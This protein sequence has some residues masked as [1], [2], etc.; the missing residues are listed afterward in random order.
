MTTKLCLEHR[1]TCSSIS[2]QSLSS[3]LEEANFICMLVTIV[4]N[5]AQAFLI[6]FNQILLKEPLC[7]SPVHSLILC[8]T[9][10]NRGYRLYISNGIVS[11]NI[12]KGKHNQTFASAMYQFSDP[13]LSHWSSPEQGDHCLHSISSL[14]AQFAFRCL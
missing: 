5:K 1:A 2:T 8:L 12:G 9:G 13:W 10:A 6:L 4:R 3:V 14:V 11:R 7:A